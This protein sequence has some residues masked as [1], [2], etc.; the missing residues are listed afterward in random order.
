[1]SNVTSDWLVE[2]IYKRSNEILQ[3][4]KDC[5]DDGD[6]HSVLLARILAAL[7]VIASDVGSINDCMPVIE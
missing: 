2:M 4:T 1:M 7:E 5:C 6:R 3:E